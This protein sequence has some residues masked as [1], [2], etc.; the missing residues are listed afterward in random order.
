M[1]G[2][3]RD[4]HGAIYE[5]CQYTCV[6]ISPQLAALQQQTVAEQHGHGD[7]F[8]VLQQDAADRG[9]WGAP[10]AEHTFVVMAEVLDNMPHDRCH[11][12]VLGHN[13]APCQRIRVND[14]LRA[15]VSQCIAPNG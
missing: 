12:S 7:H 10:R 14:C 4:G 1:Q 15:V 11:P 5:S 8:E 2:T 9:A 13:A 3:L 6:E